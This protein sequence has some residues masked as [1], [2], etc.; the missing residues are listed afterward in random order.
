[1][2]PISLARPKILLVDDIPANLLAMQ[3]VLGEIEADLL[4]AASGEAALEI[5]ML[6][7]EAPAL[8]LLDVQMPGMD[9]FE[10][11]R[12][13]RSRERMRSMPIIFVS[14]VYGDVSHINAGYDAGA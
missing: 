3:I 14:A 9:G 1:M 8:A 6:E 2:T 5:L 7:K 12:L 10:L 4:L 11:A 13:I